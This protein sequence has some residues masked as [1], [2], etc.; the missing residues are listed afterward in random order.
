M[1]ESEFFPA[2]PYFTS[3]DGRNPTGRISLKFDPAQKVLVVPL[4]Y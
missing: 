1:V 4:V 2:G 3:G